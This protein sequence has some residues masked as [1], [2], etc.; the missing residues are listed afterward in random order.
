MSVHN[1]EVNV[2][3]N[4]AQAGKSL[5]YLQSLMGEFGKQGANRIAAIAGAAAVAKMAFDKMSQSISANIATAKQVSQMAIKFNIDPTAMHSITMAAKDAGVSVRSLTMAM[6]SLGKTAEKALVSKEMQIN[7]QQLG[8]DANKLNEIQKAPSKFLPEIS[9]ALMEIGDENQRSAAGAMLLGRQYQMLLPLV[10]DLGTSEEARAKFLENENA[11]TAEQIQA[12]KEIAQLQNEMS[13]GFDKM[14]ASAAPLLN[15]AMNFVNLL[16]QGLGFLVDMIGASDKARKERETKG[17]SKAVDK[18]KRYQDTLKGK[19]ESGTLDP[20]EFEGI[21]QAGGVEKYVEN[22]TADMHNMINEDIRYRESPFRP[23]TKEEKEKKLK[24]F[25]QRF[26]ERSKLSPQFADAMGLNFNGEVIS[27]FETG[28][29]MNDLQN[30]H[31]QGLL[32]KVV[33]EGAVKSQQEARGFKDKA[34]EDRLKE[35]LSKAIG[36]KKSMAALKGNIYDTVTDGDYSKEDYKLLLKQRGVSDLGI[37]DAIKTYEDESVR[38]KRE[39]ATKRSEEKLANSERKLYV[40]DP[41]DKVYK[42]GLDDKEKAREALEDAKFAQKH[43]LKDLKEQQDIMGDLY[44][45]Q[46]EAEYRKLG[47]DKNADA[48]IVR[49]TNLL[50]TEQIKLNDL[51]EKANDLKGAEVAATEALKSASE[52]VY[53]EEEKRVDAVEARLK[54]EEDHEKNLKYKVMKTDKKSQRDITGERLKDEEAEY[55]KMLARYKQKLF[56]AENNASKGLKGEDLSDSETKE[57]EGL[58]KELDAKKRSILDTAFDFGNQGDKGQVTSMRRIGGGGM[59]YGGL[60]NTAKQQL[61]IARSSLKQ[62]E[63]IAQLSLGQPELKK[64]GNGEFSDTRLGA[65]YGQTMAVGTDGSPASR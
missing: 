46:G 9:K 43:P 56:D 24:H 27:N 58:T 22:Q 3:A 65:R 11:M 42:Q 61:D 5:G 21:V 59:E 60:A 41:S 15:W 45:Q 62:L 19:F 64:T 13:D 63:K 26:L 52:K 29:E 8:I 37:S 10:E 20:K 6:K 18:I 28:S 39:K 57:L 33:T 32:A 7:F 40:G 17:G 2:T 14:M 12:N 30:A 47:G 16:G 23:G 48:D 1:V 36:I 53:R 31:Q 4:T 34:E 49:I 55:G 35:S 54:A 38:V 50:E 51:Q 44:V 25:N